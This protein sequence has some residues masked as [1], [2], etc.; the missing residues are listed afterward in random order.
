MWKIGNVEIKNRVVLAPMAGFTS[1][2]YRLLCKKMGV[3][4]VV[5]EMVSDKALI[6]DSKKTFE[7][8]KFKE[9]E[10]PIAIQL[11][12]GDPDSM[13]KAAKI[14]EDAV[15]P[16]IIDINMGCPVPKIAIKSKAGSSL[17]KN[18]EL[19]REIVASVVKSVSVPVTVK[20]RSGWDEEHINAPLVAK[21]C[22]EAGASAI[23][24]HGRTRKQGY[25]GSADLKIIKE[26]KDSVKIPVIGNGDIKSCYDAKKMIVECGVDAVMIGRATLGNPWLIKECVNYLEEG[27]PPK[28][29]TM[30]ERIAL[31]KEHT[32][33][34][35]NE[36]GDVVGVLEMRSILM[37]YLKGLPNTKNLKLEICKCQTKDDLLKVID[38]IKNR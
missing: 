37:H 25:S 28:E 23:F 27:I 1:S 10:R 18:P 13:G 9:E 32:L 8:L 12:G 29:V 14:V 2:T 36:K 16:D 24:I 20:I 11:F 35:I 33:N 7:L 34:N 5:S 4:L 15:H 21:I 38:E 3:G 6:Y 26:V 30:A 17:L 19:I 22:E 31:M